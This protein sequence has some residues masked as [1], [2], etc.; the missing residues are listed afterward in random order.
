[1]FSSLYLFQG[2]VLGFYCNDG[3]LCVVMLYVGTGGNLY[4]S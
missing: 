1:M 4:G 2:I 3:V